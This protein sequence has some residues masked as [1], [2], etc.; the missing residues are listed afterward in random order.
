[1]P[2]GKPFRGISLPIHKFNAMQCRDQMDAE[3][4]RAIS[5][6]LFVRNAAEPVDL[7]FVLGSPTV[8]SITPALDLFRTDMTKKILISGAG[9]SIDGKPEWELYRDHALSEGVPK[10]AL[11][12]EKSAKNTQQNFAF[13]AKII[14]Q[15]I[16]WQHIQSIALCAKP[17]HLRR[18]LMTA[19]RYFPE[20]VRLIACPPEDPMNLSSTNWAETSAGRERVLEELGKISRYGLKGDFDAG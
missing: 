11:L 12:F 9:I 4:I 6:F 5:Q 16:G 14:S 10:E 2:L 18:V 20:N 15:E 17:F 3:S 8:N 7:A 13:G 19:R 1:M